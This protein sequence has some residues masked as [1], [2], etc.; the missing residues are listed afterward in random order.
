[1]T[2]ALDRVARILTLIPYLREHPGAPI[3]DLARFLG[4]SAKE[5]LA[6]LDA[7]LMCGAPPYLPTDYINVAIEGGR[8]YLDFA[9]AFRRPVRLTLLEAVALK[10]AVAQLAGP[11]RRRARE[12]LDKLDEAMPLEFKRGALDAA[13]QLHFD[14]LPAPLRRKIERIERAC[15]DR[16]KLR[17]EYYTAGR[18]AMSTRTVRPYALVNHAGVWYVVAFCEMRRR[19]APFRADRIKTLDVLDAR[20][21]IPD[22]FDASRYRQA[23]MYAPTGKDVRARIRFS[24]AVARY[25]KEQHPGDAVE[26]RPDGSLILTIRTR[27]MAWLVSWLLQYEDCAE[28]LEPPELRAR[29]REVSEKMA[30]TY[31]SRRRAAKP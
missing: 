1:M 19:V 28:A 31:A 18:D 12:L 22:D 5:A 21:E 14:S 30:R 3:E 27:H 16:R 26:E 23:E 9:D 20:F 24:P 7:V 25:I 29:L 6:D 10:L 17:I 4:C 13:R 15:A 11:R 8:V 2:K